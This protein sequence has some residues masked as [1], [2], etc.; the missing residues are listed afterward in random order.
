MEAKKLARYLTEQRKELISFLQSHP[1]RQ[2]SAKQVA[3]AHEQNGISL[4]AVYRNL[5]SLEEAGLVCCFVKEGSREV[6]YQYMDADACKNCIHL[7]CTKCGRTFHM[8]AAAAEQMLDTVSRADGFE[9]S[10]SRTV[11]YGLCKNCS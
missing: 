11:L 10:R 6:F 4:S 9:I 2:F 8:D 1:D 3:E 5:E 7:T